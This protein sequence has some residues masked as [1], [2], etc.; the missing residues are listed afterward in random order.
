LTTLA[1]EAIDQRSAATEAEVL[2][3]R[4]AALNAEGRA[5]ELEARL[6]KVRSASK[7]L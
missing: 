1:E 5:R 4:E 7:E 3:L 6:K 2:N